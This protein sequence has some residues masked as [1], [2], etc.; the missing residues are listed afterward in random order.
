MSQVNSYF[1]D[2][3]VT[4]KSDE[5]KRKIKSEYMSRLGFKNFASGWDKNRMF[6]TFWY[7]GDQTL[8]IIEQ[9]CTEE[10]GELVKAITRNQHLQQGNGTNPKPET[11]TQILK[12]LLNDPKTDEI[13]R[14]LS[15]GKGKKIKAKQGKTP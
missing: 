7:V 8:S 1:E 2:V 12:R 6:Y 10:H 11:S 13:L 4:D 14:G 15:N 3:D 9:L 5:E